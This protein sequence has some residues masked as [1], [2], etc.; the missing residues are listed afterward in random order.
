M[1]AA[2]FNLDFEQG[3]PRDVVI[4]EWLDATGN[5]YD[6]ADCK[7]RLQLFAHA[8]DETPLVDLSTTNG[9]IEVSNAQ[10]KAHFTAAHTQSMKPVTGAHAI[11]PVIECAKKYKAGFFEWRI[12][13][14]DGVPYALARGEYNITP[15]LMGEVTAP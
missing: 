10:L 9:G 15:S 14:K 6:L 4:S 3:I 5:Q 7:S 12:W 2:I 11:Q 8:D 1:P 13:N